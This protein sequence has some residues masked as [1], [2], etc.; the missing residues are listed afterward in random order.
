MQARHCPIHNFLL[1][2]N[3]MIALLFHTYIFYLAGVRILIEMKLASRK[4][5]LLQVLK[6]YAESVLVHPFSI[7]SSQP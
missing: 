5:Y 7:I 3:Y 2:G 1:T 4:T 6:S